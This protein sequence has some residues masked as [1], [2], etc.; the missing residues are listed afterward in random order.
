MKALW[1][2]LVVGALGC[3][4][5]VPPEQPARKPAPVKQSAPPGPKLVY[6]YDG[7]GARPQYIPDKK[8]EVKSILVGRYLSGGVGH[9]VDGGSWGLESY[10]YGKVE[11]ADGTT[12]EHDRFTLV[13][14]NSTG[15]L[16]AI[17]A[18]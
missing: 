8:K 18:N 6:T 11:F 1:L 13:Y 16:A 9:A 14:D 17:E 5:E 2:L 7:K 10:A 15:K 3:R 12:I 4:H